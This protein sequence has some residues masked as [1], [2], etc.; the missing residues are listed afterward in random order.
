MNCVKET[1]VSLF[2]DVPDLDSAKEAEIAT[3]REKVENPQS[4]KALLISSWGDAVKNILFR[5]GNGRIS[6]VVIL[7]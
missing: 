7:N 1:S 3:D 5:C 4:F 2:R 6:Y